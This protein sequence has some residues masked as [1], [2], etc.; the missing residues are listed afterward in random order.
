M[1]FS[2]N[3]SFTA[4]L[5]LGL[6]GCMALKYSNRQMKSFAATPLLFA[7][8]QA[9][10]GMLWL[11]KD[12]PTS[13]IYL[14]AL[15]SFLFFACVFWPLWV[16]TNLAFLEQDSSRRYRRILLWCIVAIG[17]LFSIFSLIYLFIYGATATITN[18]I[19]YQSEPFSPLYQQ[20]GRLVYGIV[21]IAPGCISSLRYMWV[22]SAGIA[23]S[24]LITYVLFPNHIGSTWCFFGAI[25]ST[26]VLV[27]VLVNNPKKRPTLFW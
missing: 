13:M 26:F 9:C 23:V 21:I 4:S 15:Y 14:T 10:E 18:H 3:A 19:A 7:L 16:P 5:L 8:Q 24:Y 12:T 20:L 6:T 2:A 22:L 27:I 1:C 11:W 17:F 25:V